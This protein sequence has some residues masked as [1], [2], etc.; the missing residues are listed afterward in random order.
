MEKFFSLPKIC[1]KEIEGK[2][3]QQRNTMITTLISHLGEITH[4][5]LEFLALVL[6]NPNCL[7]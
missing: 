3:K 2:V 4:F 7:E 5:S 6:E 1:I